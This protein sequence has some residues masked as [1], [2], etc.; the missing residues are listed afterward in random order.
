MSGSSLSICRFEY[1]E[2]LSL[3]LEGFRGPSRYNQKC[4]PVIS[5]GVLMCG[6]AS[7]CLRR[8]PKP[9]WKA[10]PFCQFE[11]EALRRLLKRLGEFWRAG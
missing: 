6:E 8:P 3:Q 9:D 11:L 1:P 4:L 7:L 5:G 2:V 10:L